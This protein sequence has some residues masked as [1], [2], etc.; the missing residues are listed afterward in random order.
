MEKK[1]KADEII[2][3]MDN[4]VRA[5]LSPFI[6]NKI[7]YSL[8]HSSNE[9]EPYVNKYTIVFALSLMIVVFN[10]FLFNNH[11]HKIDQKGNVNSVETFSTEYSLNNLSL[12]NF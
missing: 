9:K 1:N 2:D 6:K 10:L 12:V 11:I 3:S 4:V 8:S 7:I 5:E